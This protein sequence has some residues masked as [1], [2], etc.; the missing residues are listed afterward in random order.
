MVEK[1][2]NWLKEPRRSFIT[3]ITLLIATMLLLWKARLMLFL[4]WKAV[5]YL[6]YPFQTEL[7]LTTLILITWTAALIISIQKK[8]SYS[9]LIQM[10]RE[11]PLSKSLS[12]GSAQ[13]DALRLSSEYTKMLMNFLWRMGAVIFIIVLARLS[14]YPLKML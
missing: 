13:R 4:M 14:L 9:Q 8:R 2:L 5:S 10:R 6:L 12:E 3:L 7:L 1:I 11:L